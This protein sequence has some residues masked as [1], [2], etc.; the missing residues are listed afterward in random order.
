MSSVI[1]LKKIVGSGKKNALV[2]NMIQHLLMALRGVFYFT[3]SKNDPVY[4][5]YLLIVFFELL[6]WDISRHYIKIL[7]S[8]SFTTQYQL[9]F[10]P[11]LTLPILYLYPYLNA[12]SCTCCSF[13]LVRRAG[14][15]AS[16]AFLSE[17]YPTKANRLQFST[18]EVC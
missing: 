2:E 17:S 11:S 13:T 6:I 1:P 10:N 9:F 5:Y 15:S 4:G 18:Y 8:A 12:F 3:G 7:T 14:G 16:L